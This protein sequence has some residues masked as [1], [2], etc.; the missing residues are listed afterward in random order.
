EVQGMFGL[1]GMNAP[2][3]AIYRAN[4]DIVHDHPLL[5]LGFGRYATAAAPYYDA[6]PAADRRSHAHSNY[7]QLAAEAGLTGLGA[8]VLVLATGLRLGW[9]AQ[10]RARDAE[11]WASAAVRSTPSVTTRWP[12]RSGS[13]WG[14]SLASAPT[15]PSPRCASCT[16]IRSA[17]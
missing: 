11:A 10:A 7:L 1:G 16:S 15:R 9:R 5:G 17:A 14:S 12:S 8:F 2:R 6:H 3:V 13:P 4:L